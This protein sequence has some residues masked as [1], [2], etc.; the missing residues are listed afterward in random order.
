MALAR[1]L[2]K[3]GIGRNKAKADADSRIEPVSTHGDDAFGVAP[4]SVIGDA[5]VAMLAQVQR[6]HN[7]KIDGLNVI[8]GLE[9]SEFESLGEARSRVGRTHAYVMSER[10]SGGTHPV[11]V[12][13]RGAERGGVYSAA[14]LIGCLHPEA[15]IFQKL[16]GEEELYWV[17][18][19]SGGAP[20]AGSD[21]IF[22]DL[23]AARSQL[24]E[25][26][27][28]TSG[29]VVK[30][31]VQAGWSKSVQDAL[32]EAIADIRSKH[33]GKKSAQFEA[34]R[35]RTDGFRWGRFVIAT[36]VLLAIGAGIFAG[37]RYWEQLLDQRKREE[38]VAAALRTERER[39]AEAARKAALIKSFHEQVEDVRRN[40]G[41]VG[42]AS[43]QWQACE[44]VRRSLPSSSYGY[45]PSKLI[46]DIKQGVAILEWQPF[47]NTVRLVDR[48]ALPGVVDV[49][50]T[51]SPVISNFPI[52]PL[53]NGRPAVPL[54][55]SAVRMA[56]MDWGGV[57]LRGLN[58]DIPAPVEIAPP[59]D[60][61]NEPGVVK[62]SPGMKAAITI[63][64]T[65]S[66][67][68][69]VMDAAISMLDSYAVG[70]DLLTW[71]QPVDHSRSVQVT[72][73]LYL[74]KAQE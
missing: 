73:V 12:A 55:P 34:Y 36:V 49:Y 23:A 4:E 67:D 29:T 26:S 11:G 64:A 19:I 41:R 13:P 14:L 51:T 42:V 25:L 9:W 3:L 58:V 6:T 57:R 16:D 72:G 15:L 2:S 32:S 65:S 60:I 45:V 70:L 52:K 31:G 37:I 74:P 47:D 69:Q 35:L 39:A 18:A 54:N 5:Q 24:T 22:S 59:V 56:I 46:C 71:T 68:V 33:S 28:Q 17:C 30:I 53:Y 61:A 21:L 62:L 44:D 40:F 10:N 38:M 50:S 48:K 1:I 7:F 63:S 20:F 66:I 8:A 43:A 27:Q